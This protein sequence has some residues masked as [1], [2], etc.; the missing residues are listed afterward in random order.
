MLCNQEAP[1]SS[2]KDTHARTNAHLQELE[3]AAAWLL[4]PAAHRLRQEAVHII[5][6]TGV[7]S[8]I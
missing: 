7:F 4:E 6:G 2:H 1:P 5:N 8:P 3:D